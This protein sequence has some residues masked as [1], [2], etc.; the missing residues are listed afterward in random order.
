MLETMIQ[1]RHKL[2]HCQGI[3]DQ[4]YIEKSGDTSYG[5]GQRLLISRELVE[6][7]SRLDEALADLQSLEAASAVQIDTWTTRYLGR[8]YGNARD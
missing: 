3:V 6:L 2:G 4:R 7:S 8:A 1:R 5:I